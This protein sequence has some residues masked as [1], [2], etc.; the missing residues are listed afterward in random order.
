MP[1]N[2]KKQVEKKELTAEEKSKT[3]KS[4]LTI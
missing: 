2:N 1:A 4:Q 3:L